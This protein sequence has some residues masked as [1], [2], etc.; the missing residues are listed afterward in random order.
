[1]T[2]YKDERLL[3]MAVPEDRPEIAALKNDITIPT[4][5][6]T[7]EV[8]QK[9][10]D[11]LHKSNSAPVVVE[12]DWKESVLHED[13]RC[14]PLTHRLSSICFVQQVISSPEPTCTALLPCDSQARQVCISTS[15][16]PIATLVQSICNDVAHQACVILV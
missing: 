2:D 13:D 6:I 9:L 7:Q 16:R 1:M 15:D 14:P 10:K 11:A 12:L 4:A 8:G 5:L 3:T